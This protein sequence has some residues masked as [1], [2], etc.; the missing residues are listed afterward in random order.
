MNKD[1]LL[2]NVCTVFLEIFLSGVK[3]YMREIHD[4][5][6]TCT[7]EQVAERRA[8]T[9]AFVDTGG[10]GSTQGF[11]LKVSRCVSPKTVCNTRTA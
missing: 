10:E 7:K 5:W 6:L 8:G 3:R 2:K 11:V 9:S 4:G 1:V